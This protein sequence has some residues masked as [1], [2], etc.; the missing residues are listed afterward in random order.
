MFFT[1]FQSHI[2]F[3]VSKRELGHFKHP[4]EKRAGRQYLTLDVTQITSCRCPD[5]CAICPSPNLA[6]EG[7]MSLRTCP[8]HAGHSPFLGRVR[9]TDTQ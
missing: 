2:H 8:T 6:V 3:L 9:H 7:L 1:L 5:P 4:M